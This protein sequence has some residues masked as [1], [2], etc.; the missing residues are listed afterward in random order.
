MSSSFASACIRSVVGPGNRL[1]EVEALALLRFAEV[2]RVEELL[3][4][5]DLRAARRGF[6][7]ALDGRRDRCFARRRSRSPE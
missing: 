2:R 3:E 1:G 5:D 4:A 7:N 6:A